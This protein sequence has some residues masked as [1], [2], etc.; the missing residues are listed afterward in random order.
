M[1]TLE[2]TYMGIPLRSPLIVA[3]ST[4]SNQIDRIQRAEDAGAGALV[5]GSVFEEQIKLEDKAIETG[6]LKLTDKLPEEPLVHFST[7]DSEAA[8][9]HLRWVKK[10]R[11]AVEMPIIASL[12][13]ATPGGW[14]SYARELENLGVNGL[15]LN[16]YTIAADPALAAA[17]VEAELLEIVQS[18]LETVNIP[19]S[20]KLGPY[21]TSLAHLAKQLDNQGVAALVLFNRFLQP[22]IDIESLT[23]ERDMH[24]SRPNELRLP[25]HWTTILSKQINCDIALTSGVHTAEDAIKAILAGGQVVQMASAI[26]MKGFDYMRDVAADILKWMEAKKYD[27]LADFRGLIS[28]SQ[29]DDVGAFE[30]AEY[31]KLIMSKR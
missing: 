24:L 26:Y 31:V 6:E 9:A 27:T 14:V 5:K 29:Q 7:L 3:A 13:A 20:V 28:L 18:I 8:G 22:D 16:V 2:T 25:L 19:V 17:N 23:L 10:A 11:E 21:Y 15:E 1:A 4:L 30:R 12:N